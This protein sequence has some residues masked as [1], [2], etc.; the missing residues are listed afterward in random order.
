MHGPYRRKRD[1]AVAHHDMPRLARL[2][3]QVEYNCVFGEIE[4]EIDLRPAIMRVGRHRV[5]YTA[6][7]Q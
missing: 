5:P 4:V 3:E 1:F 7:L 6:G 2:A